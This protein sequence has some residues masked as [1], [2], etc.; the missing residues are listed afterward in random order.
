MCE[1]NKK[2]PVPAY[3]KWREAHEALQ[4]AEQTGKPDTEVNQLHQIERACWLAAWEESLE[5]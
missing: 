4:T 1:T 3:L 5:S 2:I